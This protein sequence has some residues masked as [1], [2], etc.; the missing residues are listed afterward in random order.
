MNKVLIAIIKDKDKILLIKRANEP[1]KNSWSFVSG[2]GAFEETSNPKIAIKKEIKF[3]LKCE[4]FIETFKQFNSK[5]EEIYVFSGLI[6]GEPNINKEHI[7]E[8][9]WV[10]ST[11]I[12]NINLAFEQN[13]I[14]KDF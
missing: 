12:K 11:E 7:L 4:F 1:F 6:K 5:T 3:D 2:K 13:K 14:F 9:K 10:D 8:Y